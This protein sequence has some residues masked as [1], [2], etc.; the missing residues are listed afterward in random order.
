[1]DG[2]PVDFGDLAGPRPTAL[3]SREAN[4]S[5]GLDEFYVL[6]RITNSPPDLTA[7][8]GTYI[9]TFDTVQVVGGQGLTLCT[10]G[11]LAQSE[12]RTCFHHTPLWIGPHDPLSCH[13]DYE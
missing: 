13:P 1:M 5:P 10:V 4:P 12:V 6:K 2:D 7:K 3:R 9:G 11:T 8:T